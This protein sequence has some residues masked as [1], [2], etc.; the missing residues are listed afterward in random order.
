LVGGAGNDSYV[1]DTAADVLVELAD[2]GTDLVRTTI[3]SYTLGS[4]LENLTYFGAANFVGTGNSLDNVITGG[5]GNDTLTG[6][7]GNDTLNG[8][9]GADTLIG[10]AGDDTF[11]V[12]NA[13]DIVTEALGGGTDL[14]R[15][16]LASYT[17]AATL[18]NLSFTGTGNFVGVG[19]G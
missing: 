1:V 16:S 17:L 4:N 6:N 9:L 13:A 14:V 5:S 2:G 10:G 15:T 18:E 19:N 11:V 12:D 3:T 8:G 7:A